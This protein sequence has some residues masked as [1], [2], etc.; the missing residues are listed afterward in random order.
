MFVGSLLA[1]VERSLG[2][3]SQERLE[4]ELIELGL[5]EH[6]RSVLKRRGL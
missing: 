5:F 3:A 2:S 6:C 1:E 4:E